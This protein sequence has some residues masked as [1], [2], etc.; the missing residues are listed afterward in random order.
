M[1]TD[2]NVFLKARATNPKLLRERHHH[3]FGELGSSS[4]P[5]LVKRPRVSRERFHWNGIGFAFQ[6]R[7][8]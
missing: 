5:R 7:P 8:P 6:L 3:D 1:V 2:V 4:L